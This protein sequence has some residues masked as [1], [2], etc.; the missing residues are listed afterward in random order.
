MVNDPSLIPPRGRALDP[1]EREALE[2]DLETIV[3]GS[4]LFKSLDDEGRR[5]LIRTGYVLGFAEGELLMEQGEPGDAMYL[6]MTGTVRVETSGGGA[7]T[8]ELAVLGRGACIGEVSV[9]SGGPRTATVRALSDV[10]AVA[11][12]AHR[13][14]RVVD[15][16]PKVRALL[17]A[18]IEGRARA[19]VEKLIG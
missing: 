7:E 19:T 17:E 16:H 13:I 11:F 8:V 10:S 4:H 5:E 9:L 14:Q 3:G 1:D 2:R 15:R 12:E 6:L 18:M